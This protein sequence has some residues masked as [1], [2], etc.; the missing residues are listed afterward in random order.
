[1]GASGHGHIAGGPPLACR[2]GGR[3]RAGRQRRWGR[4]LDRAQCMPPSQPEVLDSDGPWP[5]ERWLQIHLVAE[6]EAGTADVGVVQRERQPGDGDECAPLVRAPGAHPAPS[7][8]ASLR[9][10]AHVAGGNE[11]VAV[12]VE[13]QAVG[14][15]PEAVAVGVVEE[16]PGGAADGSKGGTD[17]RVGARELRARRLAA[18]ARRR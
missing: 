9:G 17:A 12:D 15:A 8:V 4:R 6:R 3:R 2:A 13:D 10:Q 14:D 5:Q 7:G 16:D 18:G 1:M 11:A